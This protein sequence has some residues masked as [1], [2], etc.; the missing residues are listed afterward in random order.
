ML[1]DRYV[2]MKPY[3]DFIYYYKEMIDD[4]RVYQ[5]DAVRKIMLLITY[6]GTYP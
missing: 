4:E 5:I 6:D 1:Q 3:L 2:Y